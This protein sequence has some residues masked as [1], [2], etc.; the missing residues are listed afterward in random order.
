MKN[1]ELVIVYEISMVNPDQLMMLN[2][3]LQEIKEK[4]GIPFGG[5]GVMVF[6]DMLHDDQY[7]EGTY[8][9]NQ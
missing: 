2:M 4:I 6:G 5:V 3:M 9:R 1:F 8:A 7:S